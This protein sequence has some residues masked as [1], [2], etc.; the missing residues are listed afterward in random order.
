MQGW[1]SDLAGS[2]LEAPVGD[3]RPPADIDG[4]RS[5]DAVSFS[6]PY[7]RDGASVITATA[8]RTHTATRGDG[9]ERSR[10]DAAMSG[11]RPLGAFV[12]ATAGCVGTRSWT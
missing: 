8:I 11:S 7:E 2:S 12:A 3:A 9:S 4:R 6:P 1:E 10:F 5:S